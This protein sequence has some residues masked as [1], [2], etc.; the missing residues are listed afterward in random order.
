MGR[1]Q[2]LLRALGAAG[3]LAAVAAAGYVG[4][5]LPRPGTALAALGGVS[6][7]VSRP[8]LSPPTVTVTGH[9][10]GGHVL[11]SPKGYNTTGPGQPGLM[12]LDGGGDLVWFRPLPAAANAPFDL[13]V[14]TYQG[15]PVLTWW[16]G[17]VV[18]V[19]GEGMGYV[20]DASYRTI[21]TIRGGNGLQADLHELNLTPRGTALITAYRTATADLSAAGGPAQG[22]VLACQAQE[23]DIATGRLL[24]AWDCLDHVPLTESRQALATGP[25]A[26]PYDYFH[27]NSV[28]LAPDGDL[29]ISSR[30]TWTVYKVARAS[31]EIVWRLGGKASDFRMGPGAMFY[32]QHHVRAVA[33]GRITVFDD[34]AAPPEEPQSRGI[35]LEVDEAAR[36]ARLV[37]QFTHPAHLLA[38]NQGSMQVLPNGGAFVGWGDQPYFSEFAA[39]GSL[40]LDGRLPADDQSYRAFLAD[41][42]GRPAEDPALAVLPS[43]AGGVTAYASWNGATGLAAWRVL[44]GPSPS[45]LSVAAGGQRS[46]FETAIAVNRGGPYFAAVALDASG[47]EVARSAVVRLP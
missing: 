18:S 33:G 19:Y 34:G 38:A 28:A 24:F 35:V 44:A 37:A 46:G 3:Q 15:R 4:Y 40:V 9:G 22:R 45:S 13:Q 1:R 17:T 27:M 29:R 6:R 5:R 31:G 14:Q 2:F 47:R 36:Q 41:W 39:G 10:S 20:A 7:F 32:W 12:I 21:A 42:A 25:N 8:D 26:G 23:I 30:N 11:L 43:T 16:E